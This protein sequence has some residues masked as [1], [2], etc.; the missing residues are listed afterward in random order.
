MYNS[1]L[2]KAHKKALILD[3]KVKNFCSKMLR[4]LANESITLKEANRL[5]TDEGDVRCFNCQVLTLW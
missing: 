3:E 1:W 5:I 4:D 2:F